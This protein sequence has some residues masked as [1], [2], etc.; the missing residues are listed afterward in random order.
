MCLHVR[1][2]GML[3]IFYVKV[4]G[5]SLQQLGVPTGVASRLKYRQ[6]RLKLSSSFSKIENILLILR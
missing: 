1:S 4:G 5:C 6:T 2:L 3:S